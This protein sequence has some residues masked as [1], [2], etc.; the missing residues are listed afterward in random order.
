M[1][2]ESELIA[3]VGD[4]ERVTVVLEVLRSR[5]LLVRVR[6]DDGEPSWELAHDSLV[7]RVMAWIDARDL[8]RRRAIEL[9]RYHL[10]RSRAGAPSLLGREELRELGPHVAAI[11]ELDAEWRRRATGEPWTPSR[12]VERSR[13][14]LRRRTATP[15]CGPTARTCSSSAACTRRGSST[16]APASTRS[17]A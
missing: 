7:P 16:A 8:A 13:Q 5:G 9:V 2:A 10:R 17:T 12:L 14:V 4:A 11:A 3:M 15:W 6:G 1:R